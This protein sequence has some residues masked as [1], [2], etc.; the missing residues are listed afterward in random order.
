LL[1]APLSSLGK[2]ALAALYHSLPKHLLLLDSGS[3]W[4]RGIGPHNSL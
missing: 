4:K 3:H 1:S 2:G